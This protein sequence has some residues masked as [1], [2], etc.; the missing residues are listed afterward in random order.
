MDKK[1]Y[2]NFVQ[3]YVTGSK[4]SGRPLKAYIYTF[5][6]CLYEHTDLS[7]HKNYKY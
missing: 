4:R 6:V 3:N 1:K 5:V 7:Y 2:I